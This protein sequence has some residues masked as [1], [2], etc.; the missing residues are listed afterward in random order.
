MGSQVCMVETNNI[1]RSA[2]CKCAGMRGKLPD[3]IKLPASVTVPFGSFEQALDA[4][5][6]KE[7]KRRLEAAVKNIPDS[8]A[9]PKLKECRDIVMEVHSVPPMLHRVASVCL[10]PSLP[11]W[12]PMQQ[13]WDTY[14]IV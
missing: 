14:K 4:K 11:L 9:E 7:V 3:V 10:S 8:Q 13:H 2:L 1:H 12:L 5:E 6:N